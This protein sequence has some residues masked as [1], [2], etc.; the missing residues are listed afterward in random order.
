[1]SGVFSFKE[2]YVNQLI[3]MNHQLTMGTREIAEMLGKRHSHIKASAMKLAENGVIL[4]AGERQFGHN[5]N[6]YTEILLFKRDCVVLVAQNSPEFTAK[7]VDRWQELEAMQSPVM[8][9]PQNYKEALIALVAEVEAREQAE[10]T[11]A[12]AA[13]KA[14]VFDKVM[15]RHN[16]LNATQVAQ[17]VGMSAIKLNQHLDQ[18]GGVYNKG[19]KRGRTFCQPW[20]D[21][22]HGEMKLTEVGYPQALFTPQGSLRVVEMFISEGVV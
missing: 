1:M 17:Q 16:L 4:T 22:G 20:V 21:A 13:P 9:L 14:E 3:E 2:F 15:E 19:I 18:L 12:I 7:I 10:A 6:E 8:T 5:G 11:L